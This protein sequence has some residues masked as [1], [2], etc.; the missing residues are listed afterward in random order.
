MTL[1][2]EI[3]PR[4]VLRRNGGQAD[5]HKFDP[6]ILVGF[7]RGSQCT[8]RRAQAVAKSEQSQCSCFAQKVL[9][10]QPYAL[11]KNISA[12]VPGDLCQYSCPKR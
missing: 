3:V 1:Q 9:V 12:S 11:V 8:Q 4:N 10:H 7:A 2:F 6:G 5:V